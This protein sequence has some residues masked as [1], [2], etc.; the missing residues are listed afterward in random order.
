MTIADLIKEFIETSK[1]RLKTPISGAFLWSFLIYNWRPIAVILFSEASIE[2]KI[3]VINH[4]YCNIWAIIIPIV[5]ALIYTIGV[6]M[7]MLRIDKILAKTKKDRIEKIYEDKGHV[8]DGRITLGEKEFKLKNIES[9]NKEI[10]DLLNQIET[11]K[12]QNSV[13][14]VSINQINESNNTVIEGLNNNLKSLKES[15]EKKENEVNRLTQIQ[16]LYLDN[17][18]HLV[19]ELDSRYNKIIKKVLND[20]LIKPELVVQIGMTADILSIK[21]YEYLER[22]KINNKNEIEIRNPNELVILQSLTDKSVL[23]SRK[24]GQEITYALTQIGGIIY[25]ILKNN[26]DKNKK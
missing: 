12:E 8:L 23:V 17:A 5:I 16:N 21:E 1:E 22:L 9:G 19:T 3:V 2:D 11:L 24:K 25:E 26:K 18:P 4:E 10:E 13:Q 20:S 6:P 14:Q 15:L 7:A